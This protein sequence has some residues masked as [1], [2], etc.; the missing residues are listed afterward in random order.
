MRIQFDFVTFYFEEKAAFIQPYSFY[1]FE[2]IDVRTYLI[3]MCVGKKSNQSHVY[4]VHKA[5]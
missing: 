4:I 2:C 3:T 1:V 5:D